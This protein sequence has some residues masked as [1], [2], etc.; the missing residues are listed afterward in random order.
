MGATNLIRR[1]LVHLT[2]VVIDGSIGVLTPTLVYFLACAKALV[3]RGDDS[4]ASW[5]LLMGES[6]VV[7]LTAL[8]GFRSKTFTTWQE[9]KRRRDE[10]EAIARTKATT[11]GDHAAILG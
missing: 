6:G 11:A 2:P 1:E 3:A 4:F 9:G 7:A 10:T 5:I 8:G